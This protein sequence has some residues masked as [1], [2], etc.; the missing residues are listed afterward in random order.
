MHS[1]IIELPFIV[2]D[3][4]SAQTSMIAQRFNYF[5][6][7]DELY[8]TNAEMIKFAF[9]KLKKNDFL[10]M[11]TMDFV[12]GANQ[13]W[14]SNYIQNKV[15]KMGF[16]LHDTFILVSRS[17]ILTTKGE[18]QHYARKCHSYF[19]CLRKS[20]KAGVYSMQSPFLSSQHAPTLHIW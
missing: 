18:R 14:V 6:S 3:A 19:L 13:Y 10:V 11:K 5:S 7:I 16:T 15:R 8:S 4:R 1:V 12:F 17:K 20:H 9:E 2:K